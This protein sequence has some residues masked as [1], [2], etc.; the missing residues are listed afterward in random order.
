MFQNYLDYTNDDCMNIFTQGQV[1]RMVTVIENSPR[2]AS[3]TTSRGLSDP[4]PIANELGIKEII[5]PLSGECS[6]AFTPTV[7]IRN[8]GNNNV[9]SA[10]IRLKKDGVITETKDFT[11][12]PAL[13]ALQSKTVTFTPFAFSSGNHNV[14]F[15]ILL[16]NS[17]TDGLSAKQSPQPGCPGPAK[18]RR[19][20]SGELYFAS[21]LLVNP[22]S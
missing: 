13:S 19:A 4:T 16:T 10:R 20:F 8:Y 9:T 17:V 3:L 6:T 1:N 18:H 14:T 15:E 11:F 5:S 21:C 7:E 2:R 12:N 22:Q